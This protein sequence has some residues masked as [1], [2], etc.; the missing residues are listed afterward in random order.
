MSNNTRAEAEALIAEGW[1]VWPLRGKFPTKAGFS[2]ADGPDACASLDDFDAPDVDV[3][4]LCGPCLAAGPG[5]RFVLVDYD[6]PV[7][8][9]QRVG[10]AP[11]LTSK[12]GAHE[13]YRVPPGVTGFRQTTRLRSG[14]GWAV[15]T[16]DYGGYGKETAAG[17]PLWDDGPD[18]VMWPRDMTQAEVDRLFPAA[19]AP[20]PRPEYTPP[21]RVTRPSQA[22]TNALATR[23]HT[24]PEGTNRLAGAVG[25]IL[26]GEWGWEDDAIR[27]YFDTWLQHSDP[28]HVGSALRAAARRRA[29]D[30]IQGF[31]TLA[32]EGVDFRAEAPAA[33][34]ADELWALLNAEPAQPATADAPPTADDGWGG[35]EYGGSIAAW[36]APDVPWVCEALCLAPGAPG[37]LTG[38]GGSGKT[39]LA[40][41]LAVCV[42]TGRPLLGTYPV[43]QGSVTH[44]DY[45]Q[46]ADL[47]RRRYQQLGVQDLPDDAL[48]RL[49]FKSYPRR[50]LT[51]DDALAALLRAAQGQTLLIID[52]LIASTELENG[53]N[54]SSARSPL[55]V[56]GQVSELTGCTVLVI[57]H[58][59]KD[60]SNGRVSAR[61]SGSITDG[62]SV[63][64][65][66]EKDDEQG[67]AS[68]ATLKL[69][70]IRHI[71]P[72]AALV[73]G[74]VVA[75]D[76][77]G[78]LSI[79]DE[80]TGQT[81]ADVEAEAMVLFATGW[82]GTAA[83]LQ[84]RIGKRRKAV[85]EAVRSLL[86][87]GSLVRDERTRFLSLGNQET[88]RK[89][90]V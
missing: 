88:P 62:V 49:R 86:Q 59:K 35:F 70:K 72:P 71:M 48:A 6:G 63:H 28:R 40:Q 74:L 84:D 13:W 10:G 89:E 56:L 17:Q 9:D 66:Y 7:P 68:P 54:D 32:A 73:D 22:A 34:D 50:K 1:R 60:R 58:S 52:S 53:E 26:G 82:T 75:Q 30:R 83:Q 8:R 78:N 37:L 20:E 76:S 55:D 24:N 69:E 81:T 41:H 38:F 27:E 36:V 14:E 51:D 25:A 3:A 42:A 2:R 18:A 64:I 21:A 15:D 43:R 90:L 12:G 16:R 65:T 19:A 46:G 4:V 44:L 45:E 67:V 31:P 29:G 87:A 39:T 57:H 77:L 85:L 47:T 33:N 11:T 80:P 61:G 79:V 5:A 23:W